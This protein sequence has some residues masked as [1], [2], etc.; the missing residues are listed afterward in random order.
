MHSACRFLLVAAICCA[1]CDRSQKSRKG[2]S[3]PSGTIAVGKLVITPPALET[4][5]GSAYDAGEGFMD[6]QVL[7]LGGDEIRRQAEDF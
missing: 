2:G 5:K 3:E 4:S 7:A 6:Q 1:G